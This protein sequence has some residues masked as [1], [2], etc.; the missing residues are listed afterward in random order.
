VEG[1]FAAGDVADTNYKQ[2]I[3]SAGTGAM[4]GIETERYVQSL[5]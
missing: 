5:S 3:T 1:V 2:G 4:A